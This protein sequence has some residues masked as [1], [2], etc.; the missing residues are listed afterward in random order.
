MV[1]LG[2]IATLLLRDRSGIPLGPDHEAEQASEPDPRHCR[3]SDRRARMRPVSARAGRPFSRVSG[4]D[5]RVVEGGSLA[6]RT[7]EQ[8]GA[9]RGERR[10]LSV[11]RSVGLGSIEAM[12]ANVSRRDGSSGSAIDSSRASY[13]TI[14]GSAITTRI[15][16]PW[17]VRV[18]GSR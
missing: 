15:I 17:P 12:R 1:V 11:Q 5:A 13:S 14:H 18:D 7:E 16:P 2:L 9:I 10:A 3:R 6:V 4:D 8:V